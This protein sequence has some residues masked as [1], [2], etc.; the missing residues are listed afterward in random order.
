MGKGKEVMVKEIMV[1]VG[2]DCRCHRE[3][4]SRNG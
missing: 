3:I 4:D 1:V 2:W